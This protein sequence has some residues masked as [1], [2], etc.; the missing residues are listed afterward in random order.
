MFSSAC[1]KIQA[2]GT[3]H[4][5]ENSDWIIGTESFT[6]RAV[7]HSKGPEELQTTMLKLLKAQLDKLFK[8]AL[9]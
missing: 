6:V 4:F 8:P 9:L 7:K 1:Q 3:K 5:E 2:M